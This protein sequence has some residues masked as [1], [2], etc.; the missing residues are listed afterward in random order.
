MATGR[1]L[2]EAAWHGAGGKAHREGAVRP[3]RPGVLP[4]GGSAFRCAESGTEEGWVGGPGP[5][6]LAWLHPVVAALKDD[7]S[8]W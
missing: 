5:T 8:S 1:Q 7:A 3:A 4:R 6:R 2:R